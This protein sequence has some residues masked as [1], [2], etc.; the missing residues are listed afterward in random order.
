M[1]SNGFMSQEV[2]YDMVGVID[3]LN[4]DLKSFDNKYYKKELN[5]NLDKILDNLKLL[6][7]L[8]FWIEITTLIIPTK[9]DSK[10]ELNNIAEFIANNLGIE[11]PWHISAFHPDYKEIKLPKTPIKTLKK[12]YKIGI[13]NGLKY[14]YMGNIGLKIERNFDETT[15]GVF[16]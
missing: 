10:E 8:G 13:K 15:E 1:V 5:G 14:V 4:I 2:I 3:A 6:K 11:T 16:K 7:K 12:A 9:N